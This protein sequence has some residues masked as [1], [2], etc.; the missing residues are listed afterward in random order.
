[1][2]DQ[3]YKNSLSSFDLLKYNMDTPVNSKYWKLKKE[4]FVTLSK[5]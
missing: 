4:L 5:V 3:T 1:M 2:Y